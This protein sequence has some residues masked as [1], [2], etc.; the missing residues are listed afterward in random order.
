MVVRRAMGGLH[1]AARLRPARQIEKA[2]VA[3]GTGSKLTAPFR[4]ARWTHSVPG[5]GR[6]A[7]PR[8]RVPLMALDDIVRYF[9]NRDIGPQPSPQAT[10]HRFRRGILVTV[11]WNGFRS[12]AQTNERHLA[13]GSY[14]G[15]C[16]W[17][18]NDGV[19]LDRKSTRLNSS[20]LGIS[21]AV[22]C[23]K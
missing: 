5:D 15:F 21:Y 2:M 11:E 3:P 22:F 8:I 9:V 12:G 17:A 23:L 7:K 16:C 10:V 1:V 18:V 4:C 14:D 13:V 19:S 20:H 6:R